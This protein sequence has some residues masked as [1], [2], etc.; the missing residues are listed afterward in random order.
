M[1]AVVMLQLHSQRAFLFFFEYEIE[2]GE[3]SR[4]YTSAFTAPQCS[5]WLQGFQLFNGSFHYALTSFLLFLNTALEELRFSHTMPFQN[6][7]GEAAELL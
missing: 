6:V 4:D 2:S 7:F 3:R 5:P 1:A